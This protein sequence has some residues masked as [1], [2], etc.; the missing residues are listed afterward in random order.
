LLAL[1]PIKS[2][3]LTQGDIASP[4][5]ACSPTLYSLGRPRAGSS[6]VQKRSVA[7]GPGGNLSR[8]CSTDGLKSFNS[9]SGEAGKEKTSGRWVNQSDHLHA[10]LRLVVRMLGL[11]H[12]GGL[13]LYP[14]TH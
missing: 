10:D 13:D 3:A 2:P 12:L 4:G 8:S 1:L 14:A 9:R 6:R 5:F 7:F 11:P